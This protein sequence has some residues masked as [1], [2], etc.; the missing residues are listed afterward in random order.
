MCAMVGQLIQKKKQE[1]KQIKEEQAANARYWKIPTCCDDDD[2]DSAITPNEPVDSLSM[3]D[4]H[5]NTISSLSDEDFLEEIY[6]NPLFEEEIIPMKIDQHHFNAEFDLIESMLNHDFSIISSSSKIDSL[7]DE[8]ADELT[9][10][11]SIPSGID[12]TYCYHENEIHLIERLLYDNSSPRPLKEFV[13][14]NSN[15]YIESFSPY[16][17]PVEDSDSLIKEIDLFLTPDDPMPPSIEDDDDD[18]ERDILIL[19]ELL[20]NYSLSLPVIESFRFD[21]PSFSRPPAKPPDYGFCSLCNSRNS[22]VYDPNPN[23]FDCPPDS[24]HPPHPTYETYSCDSYE[25]DSHFGYDCQ[26]QFPLNYESEPGYI[27]NYNSYLYD[28]SNFPQQYPCCEYCWVLPEADHCQTPQYTIN[29]LIFNAHNDLLNSQTTLMEQMATLTSMCEMIPAC[30]DDDDDSAITPNEPIG[31][32]SMG[33]EHLDTIP[34]TESDEFIKYS[35]EN[36]VPNPSESEGKNGCDSCSD[37]DFPEEIYLNPL[38]EEEINSMRIDQHHFNAEIDETDCYSEED[39]RLIERLLYDNSSPRPPKEFVSKNSNADIESFSP[40]PIPIEDSD[41]FMEEIDLT[42]TP[43]DPMPPGIEE[44]DDDSERDILIHEELLDKYS[45]SLPVNESFRFDIPSFSRPPAKPPD[46]NTGILNIKMMGDISDQKV[47]IPNLMITLVSNQGKSPDLLSHR[48]LE[49]F[50]PSAKC[51]MMIH[52]KNIPILDVPFFHF[53]PLDQ[54]KY[55]GNWVKLSDLKQAL[56]ERHPML[57]SSL[58]FLFS[59]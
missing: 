18:S 54:L 24:C 31:S 59:S 41:S 57:I 1:E 40:S 26:P 33:D 44:Y 9:L 30:C 10:R 47:P 37:E 14:E 58:V 6:L 16:H 7:L 34:A 55:G 52:G 53:Y 56:R 12:K 38:F 8:F 27:E 39:I 2:D 21:I 51:L 11:K 48:S 46:G 17:I 32:L 29:H 49:I 42:L 45:L 4:E 20:V 25:N 28:S 36:L 19:E 5:L 35:V 15:A 50:Q 22:C 3:G 43:D 13:F 23:S